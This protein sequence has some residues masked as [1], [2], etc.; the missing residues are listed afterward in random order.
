MIHTLN[1]GDHI[2][3]RTPEK[4]SVHNEKV[5]E[6]AEDYKSRHWDTKADLPDYEKPDTIYGYIPDVQ[7]VLSD[8]WEE[9]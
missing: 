6:I 8:K 9:R 2:G 4:E 5:K 3:N 1:W 7:A